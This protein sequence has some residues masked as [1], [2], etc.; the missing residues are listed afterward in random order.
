[1]WTHLEEEASG[2]AGAVEITKPAT[3]EQWLWMGQDESDPLPGTQPG[4]CRAE[5]EFGLEDLTP[6]HGSPEEQDD[7][8]RAGRWPK[9]KAKA[10]AKT[11]ALAKAKT[12]LRPTGTVVVKEVKPRKK[13]RGRGGPTVAGGRVQVLGDPAEA[14]QRV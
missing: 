3:R 10:K 2:R 4:R 5:L 8:A 1:M 7:G 11:K 14:A 12:K 9:G 6:E 13:E